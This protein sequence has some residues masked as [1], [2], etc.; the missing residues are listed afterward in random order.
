MRNRFRLGSFEY[1]IIGSGFDRIYTHM[2]ITGKLVSFRRSELYR[3][4]E[5]GTFVRLEA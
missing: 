4:M 5:I 1:E 3:Y 2:T